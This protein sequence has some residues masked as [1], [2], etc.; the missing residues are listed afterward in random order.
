MFGQ[1]SRSQH[2]LLNFRNEFC[3]D[4]F[5]GTHSLE[6]NIERILISSHSFILDNAGM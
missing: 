2:T 5:G 1:E 3:F 4:S 6:N